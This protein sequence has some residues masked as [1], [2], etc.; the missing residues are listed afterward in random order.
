MKR[1]LITLSITLSIITISCTSNQKEKHDYTGTI[2]YADSLYN[3]TFE[4]E[5]GSD[6]YKSTLLSSLFFYELLEKNNVIRKTCI[7]RKHKL[8]SKMH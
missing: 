8:Y 4:L 2:E 6:E 3:R 7:D 5:I 1:I